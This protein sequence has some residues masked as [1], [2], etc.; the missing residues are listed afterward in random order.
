MYGL[1][2]ELG[3]Q[4]ES[5]VQVVHGGGGGLVAQSCPT[6][7]TPWTVARQAPGGMPWDFP[8][9]H[10]G[11]GCHFLLQEIFLTQGSNL[12]LQHWQ[13]DSLPPSHQGSPY[14]KYMLSHSVVSDK[15]QCF[16]QNTDPDQAT[17][18]VAVTQTSLV[19][20]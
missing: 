10:T 11:V 17:F 1:L 5:G 18:C 13:A 8:G 19:A 12:H 6:L 14:F 9:K 16:N 7:V 20:Q 2:G 4:T 15:Y 3:A